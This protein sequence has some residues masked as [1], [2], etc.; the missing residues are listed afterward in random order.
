MAYVVDIVSRLRRME[1]SL[2]PSEQRVAE[3]W[4]PDRRA[5]VRETFV[6]IDEPWALTLAG[7]L[8][9]EL[10][11]WTQSWAP[12][13]LETCEATARGEQS[14]TMLDRRMMCLDRRL[15]ELDELVEGFRY[16]EGRDLSGYSR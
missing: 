9:G 12:M 6:Q 4:N 5:S 15:A 16:R 13:H 3:V 2:R 11:R 14:D 8:E 7:E 10:D 1:A